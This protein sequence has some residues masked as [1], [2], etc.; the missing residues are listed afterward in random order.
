MLMFYPIIILISQVVICSH[1][2]MINNIG[3]P[4]NFEAVTSSFLNA[5]KGLSFKS[6][7]VNAHF[8]LI[9]YV[10]DGSISTQLVESIRLS[11]KKSGMSYFIPT[12]DN[13]VTT[14]DGVDSK[15]PNK[16]K[17]V[18]AGRF[19]WGDF[20]RLRDVKLKN[21]HKRLTTTCVT[22]FQEPVARLI[23]C[24]NRKFSR[25]IK[26]NHNELSDLSP[27]DI[28]SLINSKSHFDGKSCLNE[29]Y[30]VM[31]GQR[32]ETFID[33]LLNDSQAL[34]GAYAMSLHHIATCFPLVME[35]P[36]T[37]GMFNTL[38]PM[39]NVVNASFAAL[40]HS[41]DRSG[42]QKYSSDQLEIFQQYTHADSLIYNVVLEKINNI[43]NLDTTL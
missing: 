36:V 32:D 14:C 13:Y 2:T 34:L 35:V 23:S 29:P 39:V 10:Q 11:V 20:S 4:I 17:S 19:Y 7:K 43:M 30:R 24:L 18:Y 31:S 12:C 16:T 28:E 5:P 22:N 1:S 38:Y 37:F 21:V 25:E 6:Y 26:Q 15:L 3:H 41:L 42:L 8:P 33:N 9:V 27:H 40:H